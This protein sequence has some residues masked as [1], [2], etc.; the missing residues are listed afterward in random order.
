MTTPTTFVIG[1]GAS[2]DFGFPTGAGL[3]D[4]IVSELSVSQGDRGWLHWDHEIFRALTYVATE[5][6]ERQAYLRA[7]LRLRNGVRTSPSIDE[8]L[9]NHAD[10]QA[11]T[12][13]GKLAIA[14]VVLSAERNSSLQSDNKYDLAWVNGEGK[15]PT[16]D[17]KSPKEVVDR[18]YKSWLCQLFRRL[19][20][21]Y[22]KL[23]VE[24]IFE[25]VRFICFN[26]DRC[27]EEFLFYALQA[28]Y[29]LTPEIAGQIVGSL[30]I[31]HPYGTI[32]GL[33]FAPKSE[34]PVVFGQQSRYVDLMEMAPTSALSLSSKQLALS[35]TTLIDTSMRGSQ[36]SF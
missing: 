20:P 25:G 11:M 24:R 15:G 10:D 34:R 28:H 21:S 17:N 29:A 18:A 35:K 26:Y 31:V 6:H 4:Q 36:P 7:A 12:L 5:E 22:S 32:G 30:E 3:I 13:I 14:Y 27:I 8:F 1:A 2:V 23:E 19:T 16:A 33:S 9:N